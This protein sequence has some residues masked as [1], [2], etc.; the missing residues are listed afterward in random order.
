MSQKPHTPIKYRPEID[1][2]RAL[3][4]LPVI[5]F[6]AGSDLFGGG[7][8]G[9]DVFF[10]ISGYL[11]TSI[12]L[13]DMRAGTFSIAHFYERRA[14]RIL[15]A[16]FTVM[17]VCTVFAWFYMLPPQLEDFSK[18]L[19][20]VVLFASNFLFFT[21]LDYFAPAA[22]EMPLLHTWSLGVE[23][24]YYVIFPLFIL[25]AWRFGFRRMTLMLLAVALVSLMASEASKAFENASFYLTPSRAWELLAGSIVAFTSFDKPLHQQVKKTWAEALSIIG[26]AS[27]LLS[28]FLFDKKTSFPGIAALLPVLGTVLIVAFAHGKTKVG[29]L[30]SWRGFVGVG[31]LSYSAYLWHQPLFAFARIINLNSS[32]ST[33]VMIALAVISFGFAY[34]TWRFIETPTR[35]PKNFTRKQVFKAA[36]IGSLLFMVL[37]G[38]GVLGKGFYQRYPQ[39]QHIWFDY[40]DHRKMGTY[41]R[42][43]FDK[44]RGT[45]FVSGDKRK[46][47][48]IGDSFAQDFTNYIVENNYLTHDEVVTFYIRAKCQMY[49]GDDHLKFVD[50]GFE[51]E[52]AR[53]DSFEDALPLVRQADVIIMV[54][55]W[56]EWAIE[57]LPQ[58]IEKMGLAESQRLF[59]VGSKNVGRVT[60]KKLLKQRTENLSEMRQKYSTPHR[61]RNEKLT[62]LLPANVFINQQV[63][64][65]GTGETCPLF[66]SE[67]H[68]ISYDGGHLTRAGAAYVGKQVFEKTA[69]KELIAKP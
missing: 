59:V 45:E 23:E 54:S 65:C 53:L 32:P 18:S 64:I 42:E 19:I 9:V 12:I 66:T 2:L 26:F 31:L 56:R 43:N 7:F 17:L 35:N 39:E 67:G 61:K 33:G 49:L 3:A 27:V 21:T 46:V 30:L 13:K 55:N 47:L 4:V 40:M 57:K 16:L 24:Q 36:A 20:A 11:I 48:I 8:V 44:F 58:T 29:R 6:H 14:R 37:G 51:E 50:T 62:A 22:E 10:V 1:G 60:V 28:I 34:L 38:V 15:P 25:V 5:L 63:A 41:V 69:L 52:C 68:L